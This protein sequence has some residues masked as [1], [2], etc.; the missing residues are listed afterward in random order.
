MYCRADFKVKE[1]IV[2]YQTAAQLTS[3][4]QVC[5]AL[6]HTAAAALLHSLLAAVQVQKGLI[7]PR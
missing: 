2:L 5:A 4:L 6:R 3:P 7:Q 1:H